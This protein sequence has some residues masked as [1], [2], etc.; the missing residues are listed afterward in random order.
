MQINN[1]LQV[2]LDKK[3][4]SLINQRVKKKQ[5]LYNF[6]DQNIKRRRKR[7]KMSMCVSVIVSYLLCKGNF[8]V[9]SNPHFIWLLGKWLLTHTSTDWICCFLFKSTRS[10]V[11][12]GSR[13]KRERCQSHSIKTLGSTLLRVCPG[14]NYTRIIGWPSSCSKCL[15]SY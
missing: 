2:F 7:Q 5:S 11:R 8:R 12:M 15:L 13:G 6:N 10:K 1:F 4:T 9:H 14:K 3:T